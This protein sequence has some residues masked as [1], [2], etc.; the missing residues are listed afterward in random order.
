MIL[1]TPE[2]L[3]FH[4]DRFTGASVPAMVVVDE[5]HHV[6]GSTHRSAY[7]ALGET[8]A[9]LGAPQILALT[10][11]AGDAAFDAISRTS[12]STHG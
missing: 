2:F 9:S 3:A 5:A 7:G 12:R 8:I 4:R 10:A 1:A 6:H 11:T